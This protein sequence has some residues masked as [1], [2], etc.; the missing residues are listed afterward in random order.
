MGVS[1]SVPNIYC[2]PT[3]ASYGLSRDVFMLN[4]IDANI[5]ACKTFTPFS[6]R[7]DDKTRGE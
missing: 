2:P 4:T 7:F 3:P 1:G 6:M 5:I